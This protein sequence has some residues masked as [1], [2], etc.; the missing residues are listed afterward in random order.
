LHFRDADADGQARPPAIRPLEVPTGATGCYAGPLSVLNSPDPDPSGAPVSRPAARQRPWRAAA[1]I[2]EA[3]RPALSFVLAWAFLD[4]V[5]NIRY[6]A[7]EPKF[8]WLLPS[9]DVLALF[10]LLGVLAW[11]GVRLPRWA[12]FLVVAL[13]VAI[14]LLR[15]GDG[16]K[17]RYF[18]RPFNLYLDLPLVPEL[19]RLM[20]DTVTPLGLAAG[21]LGLALGLGLVAFGVHRALRTAEASLAR[22]LPVAMVLGVSAVL[23]AY[24]PFFR[25]TVRHEHRFVGAFAASGAKRWFD[26]LKFLLEVS[27]L[28]TAKVSEIARV[29]SELSRV[30]ADLA[31][32][33]RADVFL[34]LIESYGETV[35]RRDEF[36]PRMAEVFAELETELGS[37]GFSFASSLL[38]STTYGGSS[39]LAHAT[40]ATGVRV[41]NQM[42]YDLLETSRP[43]T[44]AELFRR[45]GYRT[46]R[47]EPGTTRPTRHGAISG[48]VARYGAED[49]DYRGP[50][51]GWAPMPDQYVLDFVHRREL[52]AGRAQPLFIEY[53]LVSSHAPWNEQ[54]VVVPDWSEL[55]DGA[56]FGRLKPVR[57][58]VSWPDIGVASAAYLRSICY[59]FDVLKRYV[60]EFVHDDALVLILGD[61]QPAVEVARDR[62]AYGVPIHV[63]SKNSAFVQAFRDAGYVAGM[64]PRAAAGRARAGL[65]TLLPTLLSRFSS[66]GPRVQP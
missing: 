63:L 46:V 34:F 64:H 65:E 8:W 48:F 50:R 30:P 39:W 36:A 5:L 56:V 55:G 14:R 11:R 53:V 47:V 15:L 40:I 32:L 24:S 66:E 54:P 10:A 57:Y 28:K 21:A 59:D 31:K 4:G 60:S 61:H 58:A 33:G 51:F 16:I 38:N 18:N 9:V 7:G 23:L 2:R 52:R 6:P 29:Q 20:H 13:F 25:P 27:G 49:F 1:G 62:Q 43:L 17:Y 41:E 26:E 45:A 12:H 3:A 37:L 19:V 35:V 42:H 44:L 22:P